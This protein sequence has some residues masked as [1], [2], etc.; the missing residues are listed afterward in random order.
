MYA[1]SSLIGELHVGDRVVIGAHV[2]VTADL[3][4]HQIVLADVK[5]RI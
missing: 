2:S 4:E 1:N 5:T 3:A